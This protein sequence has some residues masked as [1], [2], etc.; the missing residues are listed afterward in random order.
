VISFDR[1]IARK[2]HLLSDYD[3]EGVDS[4]GSEHCARDWGGFGLNQPYSQMS[5]YLELF[6]SIS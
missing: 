4:D 2:K 1:R 3:S 6:G 5:D